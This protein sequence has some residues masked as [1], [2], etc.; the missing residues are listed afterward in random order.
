MMS[1]RFIGKTEIEELPS[2]GGEFFVDYEESAL[3]KTDNFSMMKADYRTK[4]I[5]VDRAVVVQTKWRGRI[6]VN[7]KIILM[8]IKVINE[9]E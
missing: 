5:F 6:V 9:T 8:V 7:N 1:T 2:Q 4:S 3:T